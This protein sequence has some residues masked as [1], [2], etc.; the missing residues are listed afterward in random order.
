MTA[1]IEETQQHNL[2]ELNVELNNIIMK[3]NIS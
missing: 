1:I 3:R 2:T